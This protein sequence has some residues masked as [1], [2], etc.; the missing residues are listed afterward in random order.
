[1]GNLF[2]RDWIKVVFDMPRCPKCGYPIQSQVRK[3]VMKD[4]REYF[5]SFPGRTDIKF[6]YSYG[7]KV[8]INLDTIFDRQTT[9]GHRKEFIKEI[10]E[11]GVGE[12]KELD[13]TNG[14]YRV[15]SLASAV[16]RWFMEQ[17]LIEV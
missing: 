2:R 3:I 16:G 11:F 5:D 10:E 12:V 15:K 14:F 6:K 4:G 7:D 8:K 17:D 1:M 13:F 9:A